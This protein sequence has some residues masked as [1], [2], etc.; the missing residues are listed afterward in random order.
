MDSINCKWSKIIGLPS[1]VEVGK[2]LAILYDGKSDFG[3]SVNIKTHMERDIGLA[4]LD[5]P[6]VLPQKK[7]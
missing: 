4:W 6:L 7:Y 3:K 1:V 2:K 5:L